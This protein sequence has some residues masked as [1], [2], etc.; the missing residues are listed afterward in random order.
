MLGH[1]DGT[2]QQGASISATQPFGAVAADF[3]GDGILDIA[4]GNRGTNNSI[5]IYLG[6]G[7]GT[8]QAGAVYNA[9]PNADYQ[10][11]A[12]GDFNQDGIPDL[13]VTDH[14][15]NEVAVYLGNGDGTFRASGLF[16]TAP[17]PWNIVVGD[18]NGDGNPDL[19]I[20]DD[21]S[22]VQGNNITIL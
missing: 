19:V 10:I 3:N 9:A 14:A 12:S 18:I 20:A 7:D 15:N 21:V 17:Q 8:F 11:L 4:V 13:V 1:G 5:A 2:F 6:N 22:D 16:S